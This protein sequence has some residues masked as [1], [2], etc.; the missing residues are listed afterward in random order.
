MGFADLSSVIWLKTIFF[1]VKGKVYTENKNSDYKFLSSRCWKQTASRFPIKTLRVI[2]HKPITYKNCSQSR[3]SQ[4]WY[5]IGMKVADIRVQL[6][7]EAQG[8]QTLTIPTSPS[9]GAG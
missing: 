8:R 3:K 9:I 7:R 5:Q 4:G 2:W 1:P 6:Q